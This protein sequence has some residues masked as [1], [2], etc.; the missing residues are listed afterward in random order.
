MKNLKVFRNESGFFKFIFV[1]GLIALGIYAGLQFGMPFYKYSAFKTDA[2]ELARIS[3]GEL[4]KTKSQIFGS[5]QEHNLPIEEKDIQIT[6]TG[7][8]V[9]V[10]TSWSETVDILGIYQRTFDFTVDVEE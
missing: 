5:A 10:R 9:R 6:K 1:T 8:G 2:K 4:E 3:I 7:R